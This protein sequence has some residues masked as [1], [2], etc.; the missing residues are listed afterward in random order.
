MNAVPVDTSRL[1]FACI[2]VAELL[3]ER[4]R[5]RLDQEDRPLYRL[6]CSVKSDDAKPTQVDI[7]IASHQPPAI[8]EFS[9][10]EFSGLK[11]RYWSQGDRSGMS[12]S[13]ESV[14][15]ASPKKSTT[16]ASAS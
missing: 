1:R 12:W 9:I 16:S 7:R 15:P 5:Q 10:V 3:D 11:V 13:A 8:E 2:E 4:G 6:T 14:R